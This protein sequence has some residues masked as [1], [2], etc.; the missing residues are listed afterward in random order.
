M[1]LR[2]LVETVTD[3]MDED[4]ASGTRPV[5]WRTTRGLCTTILM[6]TDD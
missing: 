3:V 6:K 4:R 2:D 5:Q 1:N